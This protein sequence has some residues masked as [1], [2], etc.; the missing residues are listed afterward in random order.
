MRL[1]GVV[2]TAFVIASLVA[3][4]LIASTITIALWLAA[5]MTLVVM[6]V[7]IVFRKAMGKFARTL[8]GIVQ[9]DGRVSSGRKSRNDSK[10]A[11]QRW[12]NHD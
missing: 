7:A 9:R 12:T 4:L 5:A 11:P 10:I 2:V 1:L 3:A 6:A 8:S